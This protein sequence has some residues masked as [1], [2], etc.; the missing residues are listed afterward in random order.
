MEKIN[1]E[2]RDAEGGT[3][4]KL[5]VNVM[6]DIYIK[7]AKNN[8]IDWLIT[9]ERLGFVSIWLTGK[10]VKSLF[11]NEVGNHRWQRVPPT[12][13]KGR[14]HTSSITVA[15]LEEN[16]YKEVDLRPDEYRLETTRGT[17]NGGQH[18]NTTDSCVVVT[19]L[20]TGIKVVRDGRNQ[21]RNKEEALEELKRRVNE[22]YRTGHISEV[23]EERR[24]QI[25]NG[26]RGDKR[27]TY[28]VKD[29]IVIDH[30]TGKSASLKDI[31]R[32]KIELLK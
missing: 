19:H 24:E 18:K 14:V 1:L 23:V 7:A 20:S 11:K 28:R 30:I 13:R 10:N 9:E 5:L 29:A 3:D 17:G 26:D 32:G 22:F 25:G 2:I 4:A 8:N 15:L 12:E 21:H 16:N 6:Q 27:R 31:L